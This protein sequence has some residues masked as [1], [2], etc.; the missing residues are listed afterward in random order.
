[1]HQTFE[2]TP[3]AGYKWKTIKNFPISLSDVSRA[4]FNLKQEIKRYT[5][6]EALTTNTSDSEIA[7][8]SKWSVKKE[9]DK[10][11]KKIIF[12]AVIRSMIEFFQQV[13]HISKL[14]KDSVKQLKVSE[15]IIRY[16]DQ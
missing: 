7:S 1:M 16:M 15:S 2:N 11:Q 3:L 13:Q 10:S 8:F 6:L 12:E 14:M 5:M 4:L 9:L